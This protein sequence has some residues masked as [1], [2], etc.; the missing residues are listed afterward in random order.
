[1][2]AAAADKDGVLGAAALAQFHVSIGEVAEA[3][4]T[5][6]AALKR[7]GNSPVLRSIL[8]TI[9]QQQERFE[10]AI[11]QYELLFEANPESTAAANDLASLLSERRGGPEALSRAFEI[12]QRFQTSQVPQFLDTLGWI[13]Y[14]RGDYPAALP[15]LKS[16]AEG[17][18]QVALVQYHLGMVL[19][20]LG[21]TSLQSASSKRRSLSSPADRFRPAKGQGCLEQ[22]RT[23][24]AAPVATAD[25]AGKSQ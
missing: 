4:N 2:D 6:L 16:A 19:K 21:Q 5:A 11:A 3:E 14:L 10:D 22:M 25:D 9:Y 7:D 13:Y 1:M 15:L 20:E 12:A 24:P 18:P 23:S 8:G 17:L